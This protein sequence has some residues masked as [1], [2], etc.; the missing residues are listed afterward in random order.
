[1]AS[2]KG[3][4]QVS[5]YGAAPFEW[6]VEYDSNKLLQLKV[7]VDDIQIAINEYLNE[8][9]LGSGAIVSSENEA[10]HEMSLLLTHKAQGEIDWGKNHIKKINNR[11]VYLDSIATIKY[12]EGKVNAYYRING[13]NTINMVVYP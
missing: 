9:E 8:Q 6:V 13:L 7:T 3:V 11:I 4:N 10:T 5:V 2:V 12:K 1:L